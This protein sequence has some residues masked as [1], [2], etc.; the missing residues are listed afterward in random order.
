M[1]LPLLPLCLLL[2]WGQLLKPTTAIARSRVEAWTRDPAFPV[3]E[4]RGAIGGGKGSVRSE[5]LP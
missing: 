5:G 1:M 4:V 2:G 3:E